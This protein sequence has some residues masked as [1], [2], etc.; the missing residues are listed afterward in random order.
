ML[1]PGAVSAQGSSAESRRFPLSST[2]SAR[3]DCTVLTLSSL[4]TSPEP[5]PWPLP[6]VSEV[7]RGSALPHGTGS[8][9]LRNLQKAFLKL[10]DLSL[11][12]ART[13]EVCCWWTIS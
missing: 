11:M 6:G 12:L 1:F 2:N 5:T 13:S 3:S 9:R 4:F 10:R 8:E 7:Q